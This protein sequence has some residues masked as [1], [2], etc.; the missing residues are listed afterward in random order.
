MTAPAEVLSTYANGTAR[1]KTPAGV[2]RVLAVYDGG[3]HFADRWTAYLSYRGGMEYG[4]GP[5]GPHHDTLAFTDSGS[6][7]TSSPGLM[8]KHNGK[9]YTLASCPERIRAAILRDLGRFGVV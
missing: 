4:Y 3:E 6:S 2:V 5:G 8:G 1:I 9:R 7:F